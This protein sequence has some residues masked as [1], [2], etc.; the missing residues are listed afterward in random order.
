VELTNRIWH[1]LAMV[2]RRVSL[3]V[4][5]Y[6][7]KKGNIPVL[8]FITSIQQCWGEIVSPP[9][10]MRLN[11]Q[12][13][14]VTELNESAVGLLGA[15]EPGVLGFSPLNVSLHFIREILADDPVHQ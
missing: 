13:S 15:C 1:R 11:M 2:G 8:T 5:K 10:R 6:N 14:I 12:R 9:L 7:D 3:E 4:T